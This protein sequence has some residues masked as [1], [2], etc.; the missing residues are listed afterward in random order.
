MLNVAGQLV[1]MNSSAIVIV[2]S[3]IIL[4]AR[5]G[6]TFGRP[7]VHSLCRLAALGS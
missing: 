4:S 5:D 7:E 1:R 3:R 6:M 2:L